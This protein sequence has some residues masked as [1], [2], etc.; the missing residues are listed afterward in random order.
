MK[1]F[2]QVAYGDAVV[3]FQ[4][5]QSA[6]IGAEGVVPVG[7]DCTVPRLAGDTGPFDMSGAPFNSLFAPSTNIRSALIFLWKSAEDGGLFF[8]CL[9]QLGDLLQLQG[10]YHLRKVPAVL[11]VRKAQN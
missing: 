5:I 11:P 1:C 2:T 10:D 8:F 3:L 4:L 9:I 6:E 7:G